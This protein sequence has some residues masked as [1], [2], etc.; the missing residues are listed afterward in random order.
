[1]GMEIIK[2]KQELTGKIRKSLR[3]GGIKAAIN[4]VQAALASASGELKEWLRKVLRYL[5]LIEA[6]IAAEMAREQQ[7]DSETELRIAR[8]I[9]KQAEIA[10]AWMQIALGAW[11]LVD[12]TLPGVLNNAIINVFENLALSPR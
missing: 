1:M 9:E 7:L 11:S 3:N 10:K 12:V 4:T 5:Q 6:R 8:E 2:Q